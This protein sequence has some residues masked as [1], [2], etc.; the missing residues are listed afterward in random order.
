MQDHKTH[1]HFFKRILD[2]IFSLIV[3]ITILTWLIPLV[4]LIIRLE[5]KGN[6]L[7]IQK[8]VG[9][10]K[11][12][13]NC[14]KFRS[15]RLSTTQEKPAKKD[16]DR[17]TRIGKIMRYSG[18]D[19]FPQFINV[20]FGDMSI[21]GPRPHMLT[22]DEMFEKMLPTYSKRYSVKPGITGLA[23]I[24]GCRGSIKSIEELKARIE[25][26]VL[27]I[28]KMNPILDIYIISVSILDMFRGV[29][30]GIYYSFK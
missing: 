19:E 8:R 5:S 11:K 18:L 7:F 14:Y 4:F 27:Y 10:H 20:L 28:K 3:I 23:Q 17:T 29:L 9:K 2:I 26:D 6:P 25:Y 12:V 16:D 15:M 30:R 1:A 13:F 24:K 22:H 21:V